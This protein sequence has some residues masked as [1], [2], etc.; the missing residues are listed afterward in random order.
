MRRNSDTFGLLVALSTMKSND[1]G[2]SRERRFHN[3]A[4]ESG[5]AGADGDGWGI[6]LQKD[7][8]PVG[9]RSSNSAE[10]RKYSATLRV[11]LVSDAMQTG[12][13]D[14]PESQDEKR[15]QLDARE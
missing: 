10:F 3:R 1:A 6:G 4:S 8:T 12:H 7:Q 11:D 13:G 14:N 15:Q 9:L 5:E 2:E